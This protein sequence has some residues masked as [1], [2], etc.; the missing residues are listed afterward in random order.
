MSQ[1]IRRFGLAT[2]TAFPDQLEMSHP[3]FAGTVIAKT[4]TAFS[5]SLSHIALF[6][7]RQNPFLHLGIDPADGTLT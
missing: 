2:N 5:S 7:P 1:N 3:I 4:L 6:Y